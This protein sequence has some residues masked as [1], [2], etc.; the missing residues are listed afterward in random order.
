MVRR[1][2]VFTIVKILIFFQVLLEKKIDVKEPA[3]FIKVLVEL[4]RI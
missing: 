3:A 1:F 2:D 4:I